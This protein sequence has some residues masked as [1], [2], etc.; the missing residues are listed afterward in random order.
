MN[1]WFNIGIESWIN[2][3]SSGSTLGLNFVSVKDPMV[4]CWHWILY[5]LKIP[6]FNI[7]IGSCFNEGSSVSMLGLNV[8]S[9]KSLGS[10]LSPK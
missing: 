5:Q 8:V 1:P 3:R 4:Q 6:W 7:G 10:M 2:E 9:M